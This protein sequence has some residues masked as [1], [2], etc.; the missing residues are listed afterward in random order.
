MAARRSVWATG[1][2]N[3]PRIWHIAV[4][5]DTGNYVRAVAIWVAAGIAIVERHTGPVIVVMAWGAAI[6][7]TRTTVQL[8]LHRVDVALAGQW[9]RAREKHPALAAAWRVRRR[10]GRW[11]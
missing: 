6:W 1:G 4:A 11:R 2:L 8:L 7:V 10:E 9:A 3:W 5:G